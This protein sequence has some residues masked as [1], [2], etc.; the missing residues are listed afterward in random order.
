MAPER[1]ETGSGHELTYATHVLGPHLM[2]TLLRRELAASDDAIVIF[3]SSGGMYTAELR[4]DDPEYRTGQYAGAKAYAR[5]KRMQVVL[6]QMWSEHLQLD[7]TAVESMHPGWVNTPGVATSMPLFRLATLPILRP[8]D[9]GADTLVWLAA[10]RPDSS[11][12]EHFWHD[13]KLRP[14]SYRRNHDQHPTRRE[15]LWDQ[16]A[17]ATGTAKLDDLS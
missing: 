10:T 16:A 17:A 13:R 7:G 6:A 12:S 3:A 14:T 5:T 1:T 8:L 15:R 9:Q 11:G 4:D 2:T